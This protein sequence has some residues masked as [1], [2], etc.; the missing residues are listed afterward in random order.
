MSH[1]S[2]SSSLSEL[3]EDEL[4]PP[5]SPSHPASNST[6][7]D[8]DHDHLEPNM[9]PTKKRRTNPR[10][11]RT[12]TPN[13]HDSTPGSPAHTYDDLSSDTEG[14]VPPSPRSHPAGQP[15][16]QDEYALAADFVHICQ[17]EGC[18]AG[19][20]GNQDELVQHV[21]DAHV[22][23]TGPKQKITCE[24]MDCKTKGKTQ[25]SA[26]TLKG[27][28]KSHTKD[29]PHYCSLPECDR[30]FTRSDALTKHMRTVHDS[31]SLRTIDHYAKLKPPTN[32][33]IGSPNS[34]QSPAPDAVQPA[35]TVQEVTRPTSPP[36]PP[37]KLNLKLL[38]AGKDKDKDKTS[39]ASTPTND[40]AAL[41]PQS[42]VSP[43]QRDEAF[44]A[45][46]PTTN[47]NAAELALDRRD[48]YHL[49]RR[50]IKWAEQ[51]AVSLSREVEAAE[52]RRKREWMAKELVLENLLEADVL[53][54]IERQKDNDVAE[55][56]ALKTKGKLSVLTDASRLPLKGTTMPWYR[57]PER[58]PSLGAAIGLGVEG[59]GE[60]DGPGP[61][62]SLMEID[63]A[64]EA[65]PNGAGDDDTEM[66][67]D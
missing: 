1:S 18:P 37:V 26:Y 6:I 38:L 4:P 64:N 67:Q 62:Q 28:M 65:I 57:D 40:T 59:D 46:S 20:L 43:S 19:D 47:F 33:H 41:D 25:T 9:P 54:A 5:F 10:I 58:I 66:E 8:D 17:W 51:D 12:L 27:H 15:A 22:T 14:S 61:D 7:S 13:T 49:L 48:L 11:T 39:N 35:T 29:K 16:T 34:G 60:G 42:P 53:G 23:Q 52:R 63:A 36:K 50:Q 45:F 24:W 32:A 55:L 31:E 30:S 56:G 21:Q 3:S 2:A 44:G